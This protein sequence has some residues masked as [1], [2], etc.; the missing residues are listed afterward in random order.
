MKKS[1]QLLLV[2][3]LTAL[4]L[5]A[6]G[7]GEGPVEPEESGSG[8]DSDHNEELIEQE[9][10][11][12]EEEVVVEPVTEDQETNDEETTE[13]VTE[14]TF[15]PVEL[16]FADTQVEDMYK[17][18]TTV[19]AAKDEVSVKT[20]EAWIAGPS[21]QELV[22]LVPST[23]KVDYVTEVDGVAHVS[24]SKEF[25]ETNVGSGPEQMLLQQVALLMKQFGYN[26]TQIL[27]EGEIRDML[28]GHIDTNVPIQAMDPNQI[29]KLN[30]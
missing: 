5:T 14:E 20:L 11:A 12:A 23:V 9:E 13:A 30:E 6:C 8:I 22:S 19:E 17:V 4:V 21:N 3:I 2:S 1:L 18:E 29:E 26:E 10:I 16:Y 15:H 28:F 27:I 25:L 7:Q 24:F